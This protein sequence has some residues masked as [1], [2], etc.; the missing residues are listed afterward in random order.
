MEVSAQ[1]QSQFTTGSLSPVSSSWHQAPWDSRPV[2]FSSTE[3]LQYV[4]SCLTRG[5]V[6][7]LQL[8]GP[9]QCIHSQVR[10][11]RDSWPY[12]TV[13]DWRL[14]QPGGSGP[15]IYISQEQG[16][17]PGTGFPFCRLILLAGLR[18]RYSNPTPQGIEP[19]YPRNIIIEEL[20]TFLVQKNEIKAR[21]KKIEFKLCT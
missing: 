18:W 17:P 16:R 7:R 2:I 4:T 3:H 20:G 14:P 8:L 6:C 12:F 13:S 9:R 19:P 1:S 11:P 10:V 15:W 21:G 5:W